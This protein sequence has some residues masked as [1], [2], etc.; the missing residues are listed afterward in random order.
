MIYVT[1]DQIEALM[2]ADRIAVIKDRCPGALKPPPRL[3]VAF[4]IEAI[5]VCAGIPPC[6][7]VW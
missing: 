4:C 7:P 6:D 5:D 1:R 3:G 2:L